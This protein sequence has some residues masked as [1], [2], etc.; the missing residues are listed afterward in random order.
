MSAGSI[1][2]TYFEEQIQCIGRLYT[3]NHSTM[4][5]TD[6]KK[7]MKHTITHLSVHVQPSV[8]KIKFKSMWICNQ[9]QQ[10]K[11]TQITI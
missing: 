8:G 4:N 10:L 9:N 1:A 6:E 5:T 7:W 11:Y 2:Q 3:C